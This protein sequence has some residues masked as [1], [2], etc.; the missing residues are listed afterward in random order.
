MNR[1]AYERWK[2]EAAQIEDE[3]VRIERA[4]CA[5]LRELCCPTDP[6]ALYAILAGEHPAPWPKRSAERDKRRALHAM[7]AL[8]FAQKTRRYLGPTAENARL[9]AHAALMAGA[10]AGDVVI[11]AT[12]GMEHRTKQRERSRK[13]VR[14]KRDNRS[15]TDNRLLNDV[16]AERA[17]DPNATNRT[18]ATRLLSKHGRPYSSRVERENAIDALR[19]QM[20]RLLKREIEK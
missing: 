11:N 1:E 2:L 19:Q 5:I 4:E 17:K 3:L 10:Y 8:I 14:A 7:Y 18:I 15:R 13:G 20:S 12:M 16:Q 9:A 6:V